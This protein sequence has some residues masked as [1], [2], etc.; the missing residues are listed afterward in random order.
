MHI[1]ALLGC[2]REIL[3]MIFYIS[4]L[5]N[6]PISVRSHFT[7]LADGPRIQLQNLRQV[8]QVTTGAKVDNIDVERITLTAKFHHKAASFI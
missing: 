3:Y 5:R 1:I 6:I 7:E 4:R 2:S 8:V